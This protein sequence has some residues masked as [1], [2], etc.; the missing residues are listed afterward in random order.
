MQGSGCWST[1]RL[2]FSLL[3]SVIITIPHKNTRE[4]IVIKAAQT[5]SHSR[6]DS[7]RVQLKIHITLYLQGSITQ[8]KDRLVSTPASHIVQMPET[9]G[10]KKGALK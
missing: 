4:L 8:E 1:Q 6:G 3:H 9:P 10:I 7:T 5:L 2:Q